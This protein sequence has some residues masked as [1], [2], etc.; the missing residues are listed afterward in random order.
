MQ[1][2]YLIGE[3]VEFFDEE[4]FLS[5]RHEGQV[6]LSFVRLSGLES[7]REGG[8]EAEGDGQTDRQ[9]R[10]DRGINIIKGVQTLS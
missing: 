5:Q 9:D 4:G 3:V 10:Q 2:S 7:G 6:G 8:R 1:V